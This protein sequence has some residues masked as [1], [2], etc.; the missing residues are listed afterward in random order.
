MITVIKPRRMVWAERTACI[1]EMRYAYNRRWKN[2][3]T[4]ALTEI[5]LENADWLHLV[6]DR[7]IFRALVNAVINPAVS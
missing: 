1:G 4:M 5:G 3:I 6:H 2:H 7:D